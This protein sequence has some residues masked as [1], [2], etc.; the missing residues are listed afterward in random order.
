MVVAAFIMRHVPGN[1]IGPLLM[2]Y[3]VAGV[4]WETRED[5]SSPFLTS[6]THLLL[7][8]YANGVANVALVVLL[9]S[10]PT[11]QIFLIRAR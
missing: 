6:L 5:W 7:N 8:F 10:F 4:S 3:G 2:I 1:R 11:G 9:L